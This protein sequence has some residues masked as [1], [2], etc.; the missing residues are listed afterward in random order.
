MK[1]NKKM[2]K[3]IILEE[4]ENY[5]TE[6]S[7]LDVPPD[8]PETEQDL[9]KLGTAGMSASAQ[10]AAGL[11]RSKE[12][13]SGEVKPVEISM[14]NSFEK[15]LHALSKGAD[16]TK[17]R[18]LLDRVLKMLKQGIPQ[19]L[20]KPTA[21]TPGHPQTMQRTGGISERRRR[22]KRVLRKRK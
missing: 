20:T 3:E 14:I 16:L 9:T 12:L 6:A 13:A 5:T 2:L 8:D 21:E 19:E 17:H 22:T 11:E 10:R 7:N 18:P 15:F 1:L 4:M